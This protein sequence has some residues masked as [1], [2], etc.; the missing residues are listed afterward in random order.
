MRFV[1]SNVLYL[2]YT[3]LDET[4]QAIHYL[5]DDFKYELLLRNLSLKQQLRIRNIKN[6][7]DRFVKLINL[8]M[9]KY[10]VA[11]YEKDAGVDLEP[12]EEGRGEYGKPLLTNRNY[13]YNLSDEKDKVMIAIGFDESKAVM[14]IGVDLANPDDI[15]NFELPN[16]ENFYKTDFKDIFSKAEI[17]D[18]DRYFNTLDE[19]QKLGLLSRIWSLKESYSK[20]IGVGITAGLENFEFLQLSDIDCIND[21]HVKFQQLHDYKPSNACFKIPSSNIL[22]S[23][24]SHYS[25]GK[26][27]KINVIDIINFYTIRKV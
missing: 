9:L 5:R 21:N 23:V 24:F 15:K 20:Y 2:I 3:E 12:I 26:L 22:C 6:E 14:E 7:D 18:L 4:D 17:D 8:L 11:Q 16:L 25:T 27:I 19:E 13:Q 10:V 1:D